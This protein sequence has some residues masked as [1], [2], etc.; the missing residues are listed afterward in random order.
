MFFKNKLFSLIKLF[1]NFKIFNDPIK[2]GLAVFFSFPKINIVE[3]KKTKKIPNKSI[4]LNIGGGKGHKK[5]SGWKVVDLRKRTSDI[6]MDITKKKLPFKNNEVGLIFTSHTL[7]HIYPQNLDFVLK[8]FYRVLNSEY[9]VLRISVPDIEKVI[10]AYQKKDFNF[11][12]NSSISSYQKNVPLGGLAASWFYS[13][14]VFSPGGLKHGDG[15]VHCF[16][17]EYL[18]FWLKKAGFKKVWKSD[19]LKSRILDFKELDKYPH[20]SLFV[21]ASK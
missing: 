6:V 19:Y 9:G 13:T 7:E 2:I 4:K 18:S 20:D 1:F 11:F 10:D 12:F 14:R 8:E 21:E 16:D 17:F 3:K 15:H 5:I